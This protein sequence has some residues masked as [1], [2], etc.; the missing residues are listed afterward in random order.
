L[1][2]RHDEV[3]AITRA[4][5]PLLSEPSSPDTSEPPTSPRAIRSETRWQGFTPLP[6]PQTVYW[7]E[8]DCG[9]DSGEGEEGYAIYIQPD[10]GNNFPGLGYVRSVLK[11]PFDKLSTWLLDRREGERQPLLPNHTSNMGYSTVT[12]GTD[13][14]EDFTSSDEYPSSGYAT[15][16]A[17]IPSVDE[18]RARRYREHGLYLGTIGCFAASVLLI[19]IASVLMSTGRRRFRLQVEAGVTMGIVT[20]LFSACCGLG[21]SLY[22]KDHLGFWYHVTLWTVFIACCLLNGMLLILIMDW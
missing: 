16:Y 12:P 22:R 5:S 11:G 14:E 17:A 1:Q 10:E 18:Q 6:P 9:S 7:N 8:Y 15:H 19:G 20:S 13:T 21:L 3:L 4:A 2:A